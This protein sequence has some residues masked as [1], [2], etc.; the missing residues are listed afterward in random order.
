[1]GSG[2]L[3]LEDVITSKGRFK[4][5]KLL[6]EVGELNITEITR[7]TN[8]AYTSAERHLTLL[9]MAGLVEEKVFGKKIRIFRFKDENRRCRL[10]KRFFEECQS[11]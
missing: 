1:M 3:N 9:K 4:I 7:K 6:A 5:L 8:I 2:E 11:L 10:L